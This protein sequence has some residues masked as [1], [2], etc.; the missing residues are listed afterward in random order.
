MRLLGDWGRSPRSLAAGHD[1]WSIVTEGDVWRHKVE[2]EKVFAMGRKNR[3]IWKAAS[4][5]LG[6]RLYEES[7]SC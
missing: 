5:R 2:G 7:T 3:E 6:G 1:S 4:S